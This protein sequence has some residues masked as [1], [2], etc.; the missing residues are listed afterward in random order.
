MLGTLDE[1]RISTTIRMPNW[2]ATEFA[3][4]AS[5]GTFYTVGAEQ[6]ATAG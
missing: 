4:Q 1:V 6:P 3:N 2:F 5:P